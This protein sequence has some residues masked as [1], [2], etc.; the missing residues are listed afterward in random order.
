MH[1]VHRN[2]GII[3]IT[4]IFLVL[5]ISALGTGYLALVNNQLELSNV[6]LKSTE[7]FYCAETGIAEAVLD[8]K[9][10]GWGSLANITG[11][12]NNGTYAVEVVSSTANTVTIKST[13]KMSNFQ[14]IIKVT[15]D[16]TLVP[17]QITQRD[18]QEL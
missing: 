6:L 2:K 16:R 3:L 8:I 13:G 5:L 7:A 4:A 17:G 14:R 9:Q 15:L 11:N 1:L 12:F 10:N 18:W